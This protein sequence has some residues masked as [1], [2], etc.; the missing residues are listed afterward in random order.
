MRRLNSIFAMLALLVIAALIAGCDKTIH[1][2]HV[3]IPAPG[4]ISH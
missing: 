3:R 1:E 4:A 2:A